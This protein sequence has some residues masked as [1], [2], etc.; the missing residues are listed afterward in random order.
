MNGMR[1]FYPMA[2]GSTGAIATVYQN[3]AQHS[4]MESAAF[5]IENPS[6]SLDNV[7]TIPTPDS[8]AEQLQIFAEECKKADAVHTGPRRPHAA[9]ALLKHIT[10]V[11]L[12]H[13]VHNAEDASLFADPGV[14]L[15][16]LVLRNAA[17]RIT[18][19]SE[20]VAS[21]VVEHT[22][23]VRSSKIDVVPNGVD[24]ARFYPERSETMGQTIL[25]VGRNVDR[26]NPGFILEL[27]EECS[28]LEFR[29]RITG[30]SKRLKDKF[31]SVPN[32]TLLPHLSNEE[33]ALEYSKA[34]V[35]I[36]PFQRE[37]FGLVVLE[38]LASGTP[39]VGL[40]SGNLIHLL[41]ESPGGYLCES[42]SPTEWS[43][44]LN[45]ALESEVRDETR[46]Y[47]KRFNWESVAEQYDFLYQYLIENT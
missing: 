28:E 4:R 38:S 14:R 20:F 40:S 41:S 5:M 32:I 42:L 12:I 19:I 23:F 27:A 2:F 45:N 36:C 3:I 10:S 33:I 26:K 37:G 11:E 46:F 31:L 30:L 7:E 34:T 24:M 15:N 1:V 47:A 43:A 18:A 25:Y 21:T 22:P 9:A 39:V 13:T 6:V 29:V 44:E 17:T 16:E 35:T 8:R